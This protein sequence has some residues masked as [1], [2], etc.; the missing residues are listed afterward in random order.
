MNQT[1][2][3][4][5][6]EQL[7]VSKSPINTNGVSPFAGKLSGFWSLTNSLIFESGHRASPSYG[8]AR[9]AI[10]RLVLRFKARGWRKTTS[11]G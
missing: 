5:V 1:F 2:G 3:N 7:G 11:T 8:Q 9:A 6:L 10:R 4:D